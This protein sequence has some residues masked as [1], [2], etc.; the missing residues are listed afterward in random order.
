[1]GIFSSSRKASFWCIG[2][3]VTGCTIGYQKKKMTLRTKALPSLSGGSLILVPAP[4][5]EL[6]VAHVGKLPVLGTQLPPHV[7]VALCATQA[8]DP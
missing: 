7:L 2:L 5:C 1:M 4:E 8:G 3:I 6:R